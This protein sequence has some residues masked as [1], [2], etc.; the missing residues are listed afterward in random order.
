MP[1]RVY[2]MQT[3]RSQAGSVPTWFS[4]SAVDL[5]ARTALVLLLTFYV[6]VYVTAAIQA[7][8][9]FEHQSLI[10]ILLVIAARICTALFMALAVVTTITRLPPIRKAAGLE[11]R[12]SAL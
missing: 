4:S 6:I 1:S 12:I 7:A 8:H 11:P 2:L 5:L 10:H 3:A 9:N